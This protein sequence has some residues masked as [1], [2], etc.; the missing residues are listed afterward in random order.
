MKL[1][2]V[3]KTGS[4]E[5]RQKIRLKTKPEVCREYTSGLFGLSDLP[6]FLTFT[7]YFIT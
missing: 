6:T 5:S 7:K 3:R 4:L 1:Y 2:E